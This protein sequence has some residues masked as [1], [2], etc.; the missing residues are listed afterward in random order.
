MVEKRKMKILLGIGNELNG[1]D[2]LGCVIADNFI[3]RDWLSVNAGTA[4][5]N[6]AGRIKKEKPTSLIIVDAA[7]MDLEP[8]AIRR[9]KPEQ[10][11]STFFTTHSMPVSKLVSEVKPAVKEIVLIGIQPKHT[12][13]LK[14]LSPE[15]KKAAEKT[16]QLIKQENWHKIKEL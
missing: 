5:G 15:A 2:A 11:N 14:K 7:E 9:I 6:F 8:G 13:Q 16:I 10:A 1:D 4:P 12:G 3:A